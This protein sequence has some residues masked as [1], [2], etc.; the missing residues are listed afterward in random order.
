[1]SKTRNLKKLF[2]DFK[3]E[4]KQLEKKLGVKI[5]VKNSFTYTNSEIYFKVSL[6]YDEKNYVSDDDILKNNFKKY[7]K[8]DNISKDLLDSI[9]VSDGKEYKVIGYDTKKRKYNYIIKDKNGNRYKVDAS[10]LQLSHLKKS[11]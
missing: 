5:N 11:A 8:F 1:M 7:C 9:I 6:I 2:N 4:V 10:F 3:K